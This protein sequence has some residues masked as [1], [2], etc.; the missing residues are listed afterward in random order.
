MVFRDRL[1]FRS[2]ARVIVGASCEWSDLAARGPTDREAVRELTRRIERSMR[3]VTLN[4]H[5]WQDDQLV[6]M[7][8][9]VWAAEF[10]LPPAADA[11]LRR[12]EA[13][14]AALARLRLGENTTWRSVIRALRSHERILL[15]LGLTPATLRIRVSSGSAAVWLIRRIPL[16]LMTPI[17]M[18]G[19]LLFWIPRELTG[20]IGTK[21]SRKEGEDSIPTFRV[22]YGGVI[23][24]AWFL[25]LGAAAGVAW[26]W[27]AGMLTVLA[28]PALAFAAMTIG[29]SRRFVWQSIRRY[30]T[31]RRHPE[32]VAAL[33]QRQHAL[34]QRLKE[35]LTEAGA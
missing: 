22:M 30:F 11:Q 20:R 34:A 8:E 12:L 17:A 32:R 16:L 6:R 28:L 19:F 1:T 13:T 24:L 18:L 5:Q 9:A 27:L 15:R 2:P 3:A 4:L 7:A 33:R 26:G 29:E 31:L 21:A 10:E 35:L 23:F 25:A 14:T